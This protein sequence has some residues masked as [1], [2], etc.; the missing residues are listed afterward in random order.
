M[1]LGSQPQGA[2]DFLSA[3]WSKG[4]RRDGFGAWCCHRQARLRHQCDH[5]FRVTLYAV[6][7]WRK[8]RRLNANRPC[9]QLILG[10]F[11]HDVGKIG[12]SDTI[13]CSRRDKLSRG[14]VRGDAH[15]C[16]AWGRYPG[17]N[18]NGCTRRVDVDR[19][20]HHEKFDGSRLSCS[21]ISGEQHSAQRPHFR[22]WS[23]S[24]TRSTSRTPVQGVDVRRRGGAGD[25]PKRMRNSTLRSA[26]ARLRLATMAHESHARA[27]APPAKRNF[28][29]CCA[30]LSSRLVPALASL[31]LPASKA[32]DRRE[33]G[34]FQRQPFHAR[35]A[36]IHLNPRLAAAAPQSE[37]MTPRPNL[38]CSNTHARYAG[39]WADRLGGFPLL[40][41]RRLLMPSCRRLHAGAS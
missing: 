2:S 13:S 18:Q 35:A 6:R 16:G 20:F 34:V 40:A 30:E 29:S 7:P 33:L 8:G 36:E 28:R 39:H 31:L 12:I 38:A 4:Q 25:R 17:R 11:L 37:T 22:R 10:A 1:I 19:Q 32:S 9:G 21:G 41:C 26:A 3:R 14:R 5:N 27:L 15:T 24:S 23:T